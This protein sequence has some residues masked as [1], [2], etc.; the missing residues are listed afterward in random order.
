MIAIDTDVFILTKPELFKKEKDERYEISSRL[1]LSI[2]E[3]KIEGATT[4]FNL[5]EICGIFGHHFSEDE[6]KE[7]YIDFARKYNL[8]LLF[9][10]SNFDLDIMS[11]SIS[12]I[13]QKIIKKM[14]INDAIII[15]IVEENSE[16]DTF[17]TWNKKHFEGKTKLDVRTPAEYLSEYGVEKV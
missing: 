14:K 15:N 7:F 12:T 9:P 4:I 6:L 3:G 2:K 8:F 13:F 11:I 17:I 5:L 16:V 1:L 10:K